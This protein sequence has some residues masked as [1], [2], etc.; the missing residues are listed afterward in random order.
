LDGRR[1]RAG[2]RGARPDPGRGAGIRGTGRT[3]TAAAAGHGGDLGVFGTGHPCAG[4]GQRPPDQSLV[5][6]PE[7]TAESRRSETEEH[8]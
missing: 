6:G 3:A 1:D 5:A 7:E 8:V 2:G 4:Q